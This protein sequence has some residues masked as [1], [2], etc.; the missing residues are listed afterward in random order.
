MTD[1][2]AMPSGVLRNKLGIAD[3]DLLATAEADITRAVLVRLSAHRLPGEY[4]LEHLRGFHK[5]IFGAI[6]P[7]AG[8]LRTVEIAKRTPFCPA[9]HLHSYAAE[10]F[11]RLRSADHLRGLPRIDFVRQLAELYGDINA[12]HPFRE[13][14]GRAQRAFLLQLAADAGYSI[15][16]ATLDAARNEEASIKSFLGDNSLIAAILEDLITDA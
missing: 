10:V 1:P 11:G 14:N 2:Y 7:W 15:S 8:Q 12:L 9:I 4:D 5:A 16:W 3:P 6:Y 13:G